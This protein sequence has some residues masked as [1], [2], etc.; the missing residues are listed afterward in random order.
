MRVN[1]P[2]PTQNRKESS[3]TS[4]TPAPT[5]TSVLNTGTGKMLTDFT[6]TVVTFR[7]LTDKDIEE[8]VKAKRIYGGAGAYVPETWARVFAKMDGSHTNVLGTP[9]EKLIPMLREAGV[10]V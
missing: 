9:T 7:D 6:R 2:T 4:N 8:C 3:L 1:F 10:D 5:V